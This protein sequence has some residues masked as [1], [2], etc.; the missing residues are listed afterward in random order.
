[1]AKLSQFW[2]STLRRLMSEQLENPQRGPILA[3]RARRQSAKWRP[4]YAPPPPVIEFIHHGRYAWL[5]P[6]VAYG[7]DWKGKSYRSFYHAYVGAI[8]TNRHVA[9]ELV[10]YS[11]YDELRKLRKNGLI[12]TD[13]FNYAKHLDIVVSLLFQRYSDPLW[14]ARL[15]YDTGDSHIRWFSRF[16]EDRILGMHKGDGFNVYGNALV[17][18]RE[19]MKLKH[20]DVYLKQ[21]QDL[22]RTVHKNKKCAFIDNYL[23]GEPVETF[24]RSRSRNYI[25]MRDQSSK[26]GFRRTA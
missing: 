13:P 21:Q 7:Y 18:V 19:A 23:H 15:I 9:D 24:T 26:R 8:A 2:W 3:L 25:H 12:L 4:P 1:M 6:R 16:A 20:P 10:E 14:A 11:T 5:H 22:A 17:E